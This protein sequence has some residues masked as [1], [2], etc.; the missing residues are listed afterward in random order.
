[1]TSEEQNTL[2]PMWIKFCILP[3]N[4]RNLVIVANHVAFSRTTS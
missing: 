2:A 1:M 3:W 4:L